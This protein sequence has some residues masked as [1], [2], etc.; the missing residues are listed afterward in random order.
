MTEIRMNRR[1]TIAVSGRFHYHNYVDYLKEQGAL[2][3]FIYSH[4]VKSARELLT[5][6]ASDP[7]YNI[8]PKQ[9]LMLQHIRFRQLDLDHLLPGML[10]KII[11]KRWHPISRQAHKL[12]YNLWN[13]LAPHYIGRCEILHF[14]LVQENKEMTDRALSQ[15]SLLLAEAVNTHPVEAS[16]LLAPEYEFLNIPKSRIKEQIGSIR[17]GRFDYLLAPSELVKNSFVKQGFPKDKI[18]VLHYGIN[19]NS[20]RKIEAKESKNDRSNCFRVVCLAY[21]SPR[22]G[23][24]HLLEAWKKL[25]LPD[26]EL[27][28][29]GRLDP[30]MR[31]K[32]SEY[33]GLFRHISH[34]PNH[35]LHQIHNS[36]DIFVLP[37][38]E[39]GFS[40]AVGEAMACGLPT[41][42]T[43][44]NGA[45][46]ILEHGKDGFVISARSPEEIAQHIEILYRDKDLRS[47]MGFS[48]RQKASR[49]SWKTYASQL[50][51]IYDQIMKDASQKDRV[52]KF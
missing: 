34:V 10:G 14:M 51:S 21:I 16:R 2:E 13:T 4:K 11:A 49:L 26:S 43:R 31:E 3:S 30:N 35:L 27:L 20:F 6:R 44:N 28:L 5:F 15:G 48:A 42:T 38:I 19:L 9:Y 18:F 12:G 24:V 52:P 40:L 1:V 17:H 41:I 47:A 7:Y 32:I 23:Q 37:T 25:K 39:D 45:A 8:W 46:E 22:K 33:D 50:L 36:A 29:I